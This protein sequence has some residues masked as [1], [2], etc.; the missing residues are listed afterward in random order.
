LRGEDCRFEILKFLGNNEKAS[1]EQIMKKVGATRRTTNNYLRDLYN[2]KPHRLVYKEYGKRG[3]YY[4][5]EEGKTE[6]ERQLVKRGFSNVVNKFIDGATEEELKRL[7]TQIEDLKDGLSSFEGAF[8]FVESLSNRS[9]FD[10]SKYLFGLDNKQTF[11][12]YEE[13]GKLVDA[14]KS[15]IYDELTKLHEDISEEDF[16]KWHQNKWEEHEKR[17]LGIY[18]FII[19]LKE[20]K[21][22]KI[23][24]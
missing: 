14:D 16:Q 17:Y 20:K 4:L 21:G 5:T 13:Y 1:F 22:L 24:V 12:Y 15:R 19:W 7:N 9:M 18:N 6:T 2:E 23:K 10:L 3:K 8:E 11:Q